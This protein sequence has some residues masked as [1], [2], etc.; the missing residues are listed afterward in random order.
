[1]KY[2]IITINYNN[3]EGLR[4]TIE[5]V[6]NQ[7]YTDFEYIVIDGG[8]TDGSVEV[9]NQY[10][11]Q[12][13]YWVSEPD[14]GLYNAMNK[15]IAQAHG[16]YLN[17]MNSGDCFYNKTILSKFSDY[18]ED[19]IAAQNICK[20]N[21]SHYKLGEYSLYDF[22]TY[23]FNHQA[24]VI[25]RNLFEH[26]LYDDDFKIIADWKFVIRMAVLHNA[27]FKCYDFI[28][29]KTEPA[30]VSMRSYDKIKEE[31]SKTLK[32][33][34]PSPILI[35]YTLLCKIKSPILQQ[36]P[37]LSSRNRLHKL[38]Q[39]IINILIMFNCYFAK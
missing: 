11:T 16:E 4:K 39:K 35:D 31:K 19:I 36:L 15:G 17:F 9:I 38:I 2:S 10:V 12:I 18:N 23:G 3:R 1:M 34:L 30:G 33:L 37:Y 8:S 24:M 28:A 6:I 26:E 25:K 13:D 7:T 27:K 32:E 21:V 14:N 22:C 20:Q 5:S 29:A